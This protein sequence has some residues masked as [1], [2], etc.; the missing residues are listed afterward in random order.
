MR[1]AAVL[2][3]VGLLAAT[4]GAV[5]ARAAMKGMGTGMGPAG[6]HWSLSQ[7]LAAH[8]RDRRRLRAL[9]RRVRGAARPPGGMAG[10]PVRLAIIYPADAGTDHWQRNVAAVKG[11]LAD[12]GIPY[13]LQ[14]YTY[15]TGARD[16]DPVTD[17]AR[18]VA[19]ALGRAPDYLL[20]AVTAAAQR[21]TVERLLA[22]AEPR[23]ILLNMTTPVRA[24][25]KT[26]PF[27]YVGFDHARGSGLLA[28]AIRRHS[29]DRPAYAVLETE[30]R[31]VSRWRA[32]AFV[33]AMNQ[34]TGGRLTARYRTRGSRL[35][36]RAAARDALRRHAGLDV[37]FASSP[38]LALGAAAAVRAADRPGV[39]VSGW[40]G[41]SAELA[42]LRAGRL[43]LTVMRM[44]DDA[45]VAVAEA[46]ALA[47]AGRAAA[48]PTVYSGDFVVVTRETPPEAIAHYARRAFRYSGDRAP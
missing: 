36:G 2:L 7:W 48:V 35:T 41:S 27:L 10:A 33:E 19:R 16:G 46:I 15:R 11:R 23:V 18:Q 17:Q 3:L 9:R 47:R 43:D 28:D 32:R 34:G 14:V 29:G 8:P 38:R 5:S 37:L 26:Q 21:R 1:V 25:G 4:A 6:T 24:W 13:R 20:L 12:L 30:W 45:G 31:A 22:R 44:N 42:A 39:T 40:G